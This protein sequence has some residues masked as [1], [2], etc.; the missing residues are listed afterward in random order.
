MYIV[1]KDSDKLNQRVKGISRRDFMGKA[2]TVTAFTVVPRSVL[3]GR[4]HIAPSEKLNIAAIGVG[5]QGVIDIRGVESENIVALCDVVDPHQVGYTWYLTYPDRPWVPIKHER[6]TFPPAYQRYPSASRY[7]DFREMLDKEDKNI[8][9]VIVATPDHVHAV[10]SMA[11][12]K[13]GK[14]V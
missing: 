13:R 12:I 5:G 4:R 7:K 6:K 3:G 9:A 10:A 1:M 14:H 2:A 11:A 8:D